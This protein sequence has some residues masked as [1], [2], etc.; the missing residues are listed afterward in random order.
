MCVPDTSTDRNS[1]YKHEHMLAWR[2]EEDGHTHLSKNEI[3]RFRCSINK[4]SAQTDWR[5][6]DKDVRPIGENKGGKQWATGNY[7]G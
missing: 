4:E 3:E 6:W 5:R 7:H 2:H 1:K